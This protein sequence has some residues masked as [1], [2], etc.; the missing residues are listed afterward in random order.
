[1]GPFPFAIKT[2]RFDPEHII[3]S[4]GAEVVGN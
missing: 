3:L 1:L 4:R 2:V